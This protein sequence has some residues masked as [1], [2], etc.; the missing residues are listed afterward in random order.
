MK[1]SSYCIKGINNPNPKL[2][3]TYI[4]NAYKLT[5]QAKALIDNASNN[6]TSININDVNQFIA[7]NSIANIQLPMVRGKTGAFTL[8]E[9]YKNI[10]DTLKILKHISYEDLQK[11]K[12]KRNQGVEAAIFYKHLYDSLGLT[13]YKLKVL[14]KFIIVYT[15]LNSSVA[16]FKN[17]EKK[18]EAY[19]SFY[20]KEYDMK[21]PEE[22]ITLFLAKDIKELR[23]FSEKLHGFVY[24]SYSLGYSSLEDQC[25]VSIAVTPYKP[26]LGTACHELFHILS[27]NSYESLPAWLE[28]GMASL[29]EV[30]V[31]RNDKAFGINNWRINF[32]V[33]GLPSVDNPY[34][35]PEGFSDDG[36]ANSERQ[37]NRKLK[38]TH[39]IDIIDLDWDSFN[40]SDNGYESVQ[41]FNYAYSRY[42]MLY[43][44]DKGNLSAFFKE[45]AAYTYMDIKK[46]P[47]EDYI[48]LIKKYVPVSE[49]FDK[50]FTDWIKTLIKK[51]EK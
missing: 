20:I 21:A 39:L 18:L 22:Y 33:N 16:D 11:R 6:C 10:G 42:L 3:F 48:D 13:N 31:L 23:Y 14:D 51:S 49:D 2:C 36:V 40:E 44:Q 43:L 41:S 8:E 34:H 32:L 26:L 9:K 50:A 7:S 35:Y 1:V 30:S 37:I 27:K 28:E 38:Y 17:V 5:P 46:N 45:A 15:S 4:K 24:P 29:Y 25:I 47:S 19:F 12:L